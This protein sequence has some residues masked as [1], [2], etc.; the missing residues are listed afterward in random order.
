MPNGRPKLLL[1][2]GNRYNLPAI[3]AARAA[4]F[5][6]LLADRNPAA[7][8]LA[9]AHIGCAVDLFDTEGLLA[10]VEGFGG[11]DGVLSMSEAGVRP[12]ALLAD[13]LG[14]ASI[15]RAAAANATSKAAMRRL[16]AAAGPYSVDWRL[17]RSEAEALAAADQLG[18]Y[19]LV[20][21][22][23]RSFGGS[24]GVMRVDSRG[25]ALDAFR[26]AREAAVDGGDVVVE[27]FLE[28]SEHS[29]EVMVVDGRSSVVCI[30]DNVKSPF[31]FR[32]NLSIRYPSHFDA[33]RAA[34][35]ERMCQSAVAALGLSR[36]WAHI[37]FAVTRDGPKLL[38]LGARCGGGHIPQIVRH[39][40]GVDE[41]I[42]ACRMACGQPPRRRAPIRRLAAEYRFLVFPPG[43]V[44]AWSL[45][46]AIRRHPSII[47]AD[48]TVAPGDEI[49]PLQTTAQRAGFVV[50]AGEGRREACRTADWA[51]GQIEMTYS[52]GSRARPQA[53]LCEG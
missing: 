15:T 5:L 23:D 50:A 30:G 24:R 47:D 18:G 1:L 45:P 43:R 38:E 42:E 17:A 13:R 7:P 29:A 37:E 40:T 8:G 10:A 52:D 22:P 27:P 20:F 44:A 49:R 31:P 36:G 53:P 41:F 4:G 12:A 16:W 2:G 19:P 25:E 11:V 26:F 21:K 48:L 9:E 6:T 51:C 46:D 34:E 32:V 14:L 35:V 39:V 33:L 3:R 28:G